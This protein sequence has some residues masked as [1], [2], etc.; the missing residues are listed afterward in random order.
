MDAGRRRKDVSAVLDPQTL[1]IVDAVSGERLIEDTRAIASQVRLSGSAEERQAFTY[2]ERR[3]RDAGLRTQMFEHD[4]LISLPQAATLQ[5]LDVG[6]GEIPCITHSFGAS[7]PPAGLEGRTVYVR[8]VAGDLAGL[9][10]AMAVVDGLA[11][12]TVVRRLEAAGALGIV[13]LN[14]DPVVHEMIVSTVWG[15]PTPAQ[16]NQLPSVPAVST[17]GTGA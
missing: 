13:F 7:T 14:R 11:M 16:V 1:R 15:S 12:P 10:G 3:L 6:S 8:D 5:I 4:A 17:A 2:I 9:R